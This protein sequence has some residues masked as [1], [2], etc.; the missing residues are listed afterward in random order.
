VYIILTMMESGFQSLIYASATLLGL[1]LV[2]LVFAY[3]S[4]LTRIES[5][6]EFRHFAKWVFAAGFSC[7]VYYSCCLLVGFRL[8]ENETSRAAMIAIVGV[9]TVVLA[10][11]HYLELKWASEM[12]REDPEELRNIY[13]VQFVLVLAT[14][15]VFEG[16]TWFALISSSIDELEKLT[17]TAFSYALVMASLRAVVLVGSSFWAIMILSRLPGS[18]NSDR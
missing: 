1:V 8:S 13:R 5:I 2:A 3:Q 15:L 16:L 4:A 7:F 9:S 12:A 17:Y 18:G 6:G 14:F 11:T 10:A